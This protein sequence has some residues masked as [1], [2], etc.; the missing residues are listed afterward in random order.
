MGHTPGMPSS[1]ARAP[2]TWHDFVALDEGDLSALVAAFALA[3]FGCGGILA[4]ETNPPPAEADARAPDAA[5]IE[6]AG[7]DVATCPP[8]EGD[9]PGTDA[10]PT[11]A[12]GFYGFAGQMVLD[13]QGVVLTC[14]GVDRQ[15]DNGAL[16]RTKPDGGAVTVLAEGTA[17]LQIGAPLVADDASFYFSAHGGGTGPWSIYALARSGG[18]P[19]K[20]ADTENEVFAIAV[21]ATRLYWTEFGP[22]R[23]GSVRAV[24]LACGVPVVLAANQDVGGALA[25]DATRIYWSAGIPSQDAGPGG[26]QGVI[27]SMPLAGGAPTTLVTAA[28]GYRPY[29]MAVDGPSLFWAEVQSGGMDCVGTSHVVTLPGNGSARVVLASAFGAGGFVLSPD[30]VYYADYGPV[31]CG[32]NDPTGTGDVAKVPRAGGP[33]VTLA[34]GLSAPSALVLD[35]AN[36]DFTEIASEQGAGAVRTIGN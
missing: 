33:V 31:P 8:H 35:G 14:A 34:S 2:Y 28:A 24:P 5:S 9:F 15:T 12:A 22:N 25:V 11:V 16:I 17:D 19:V 32:P 27:L 7:L 3:C 6:D 21:D 18:V 23:T 1:A 26:S 4:S 30:T 29:A 13:G 36:L 20:L 10:G